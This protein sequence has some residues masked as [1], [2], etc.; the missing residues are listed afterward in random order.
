ML[1]NISPHNYLDF[2][3][4]KGTQKVLYVE[5]LK[6]SIGICLTYLLF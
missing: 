5:M 6:A 4:Y 1:V 2:V 3:R